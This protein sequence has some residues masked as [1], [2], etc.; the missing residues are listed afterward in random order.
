MQCV[1]VVQAETIET[2]G[3]LALNWIEIR[4]ATML[5]IVPGHEERRDA[6]RPLGDHLADVVLDHRQPA[7]ARAHVHAHALGVGLVDR[8]AGVVQRHLRRREAVVDERVERRVSFGCIQSAALKPFTSRGDARG[9][10]RGV[11]AG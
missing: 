1:L 7:D 4:P 2:F 6:P 3:P 11:E 10:R 5:M 8:E 9:Q